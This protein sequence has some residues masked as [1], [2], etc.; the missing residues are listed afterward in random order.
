VCYSSY[1]IQSKFLYIQMKMATV[2]FWN[3]NLF[4]FNRFHEYLSTLNVR[5]LSR[6]VYFISPNRDFDKPILFWQELQGNNVEGILAPKNHWPP[7]C[8]PPR[9]TTNAIVTVTW[10]PL[11]RLREPGVDEYP[12]YA[13]K[14]IYFYSGM[15]FMTSHI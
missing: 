9:A 15:D 7:S 10:H 14:R 12:A 5:N 1:S 6:N 11:R 3:N 8:A 4:D 13:K 2:E